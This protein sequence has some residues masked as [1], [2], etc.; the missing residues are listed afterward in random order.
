MG[1]KQ[2]I[3]GMIEWLVGD[4]TTLDSRV[5]ELQIAYDIAEDDVEKAVVKVKAAV[6]THGLQSTEAKEAMARMRDCE[7]VRSDLADRLAEVK[8]GQSFLADIME[9]KEMA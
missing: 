6:V 7:A 5:E 9:L 2:D 4:V 8:R 1:R 3:R